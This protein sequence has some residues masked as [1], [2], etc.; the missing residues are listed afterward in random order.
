MDAGA[1]LRGGG[2]AAGA[3]RPTA[4]RDTRAGQLEQPSH[5]IAMLQEHNARR[6]FFEPGQFRAVLAALPDHL[7]PVIEVAYLL[8]AAAAVQGIE[9]AAVERRVDAEDGL[10]AIVGVEADAGLEVVRLLPEPGRAALIV[11]PCWADRLQHRD[12]HEQTENR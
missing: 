12:R 7:K 2:T 11:R 9:Q 8:A 3:R 1:A 10:E 5:A 6:G 4:Q